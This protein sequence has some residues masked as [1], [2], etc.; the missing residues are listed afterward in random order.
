MI[1]LL[2]FYRYLRGFVI[3]KVSGGFPERFINLCSSHKIYLW[4]TM[5]E[6]GAV[7][8]KMFCKDFYRLRKVRIKSGVKIKI[9][10]KNGIRFTYNKNQKR[11]CLI[12]G[13]AFS[14]LFMY[15]MNMFVWCIDVDNTENISRFELIAA[16]EKQDLKFGTFVPLYDESKASRSTVNSFDGKIIWASTNIKGSKATIEIRESSVTDNKESQSSFPCNIIADFDGVIVSVETYS[17]T[18]NVTTGSTVKKGDLL[19]SGISENSDGSV[20]FHCADSKLTA[21]HK[22]V[23][24]IVLSKEESRKTL[25]QDK[26]S[27]SI[28]VFGINIPLSISFLNKNNNIFE[29]TERL[30]VKGC[31]LPFAHT[32]RT[33]VIETD[34]ADSKDHIVYYIEEFTEDEYSSY[35]NT[36]IINSQYSIDCYEDR[37]CFRAEYDCI[38]FIGK[39]NIILK[40]N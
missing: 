15:A 39:K 14:V 16:T 21:F 35:K 9:I 1:N 27:A 22:N 17:G 29:Y 2:D 32:V 34:E 12:F 8:A 25:L 20:N 33:S 38:D 10:N 18:V 28:N 6:N 26:R 31:L 36:L 3:I 30:E 24:E 7:T 23:K 4:D 13:L 5:Y 37:Y 40:E 11:K 19:V